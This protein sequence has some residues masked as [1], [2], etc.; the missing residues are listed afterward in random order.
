MNLNRNRELCQIIATE[1]RGTHIVRGKPR[2]RGLSF[3]VQQAKGAS[4][5]VV[6]GKRGLS[7]RLSAAVK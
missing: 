2:D 1:G 5:H 6:C 7:T 4:L 3:K